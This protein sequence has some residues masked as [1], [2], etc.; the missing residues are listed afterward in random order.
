M[1]IK[2]EHLKYHLFFGLAFVLIALP[3]FRSLF[4][5]QSLGGALLA[6]LGFLAAVSFA[7]GAGY[8][9]LRLVLEY[10]ESRKPA[11]DSFEAS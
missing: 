4:A 11:E 7:G 1:P 9:V 5:M 10:L 6:S 8:V 2:R 3:T